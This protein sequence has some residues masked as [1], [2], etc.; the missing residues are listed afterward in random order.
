MR[1]LLAECPYCHAS[2]E[3]TMERIDEPIE[4]RT[5]GKP[6]EMEMPSVEVTGVKDVDEPAAAASPRL[7]E[8][9]PER[10]LLRTHPAVFRARPLVALF[11][12]GLAGISIFGV[13]QGWNTGQMH[14]VYLALAG[15]AVA[16][17]AMLVWSIRAAFVTLTVTSSRTI[18]RKG[19]VSRTTSEVQHDDVRNIQLNQTFLERLLRI[20]DI[21]I[22][23]AGQG[24]LEIVAVNMPNPV[25]IVEL[26]RANQR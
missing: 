3:T 1:L 11:L 22:S 5:C 16:L 7:A 8:E 21:G 24:D 14:I 9:A 18:L 15:L 4:C 13:A 26:I 17:L 25:R 6:F 20:G 2:V 10:T 12:F 19:L 23:S